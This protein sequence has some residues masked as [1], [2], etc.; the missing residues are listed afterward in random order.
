[1]VDIESWWLFVRPALGLRS[2]YVQRVDHRISKIESK[3]VE[4]LIFLGIS[5]SPEDFRIGNIELQERLSLVH[6]PE[7]ARKRDS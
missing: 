2:L 4:I 6:K 5:G 7:R 1:L 3:T